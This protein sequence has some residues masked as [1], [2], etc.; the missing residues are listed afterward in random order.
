MLTPRDISMIEQGTAEIRDH[1]APMLFSLYESFI[2][3]GFDDSQAMK[4]TSGFMAA[5][6]GSVS[7]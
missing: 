5:L 6:I 2:K 3:A 4:L 1:L 7:R